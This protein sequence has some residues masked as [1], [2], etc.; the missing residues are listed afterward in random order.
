[1]TDFNNP[2]IVNAAVTSMIRKAL[3]IGGTYL[4]AHGA[5][6]LSDY[7]DLAIGIILILCSA[8]WS[9]YSNRASSLIDAATKAKQVDRVVASPAIANGILADNPKVIPAGKL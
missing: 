1:M 2:V 5:P 3:T 4:A 6:W 8:V 9:I 7:A